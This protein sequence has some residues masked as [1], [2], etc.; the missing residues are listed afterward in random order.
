MHFRLAIILLVTLASSQALE[1]FPLR[2]PSSRTSGFTLL[3]AEETGVQ[4]VSPLEADHPLNYLYHSG[5]A[6]GSVML[7]DI[8]LD[9]WP[10]FFLTN[11]PAKNALYLQDPIQPL[12]FGDQATAL[13]VD[14]GNR[15]GTGSA[16]VDIDNDGDLDLYVCS[17][18]G[19][20]ELY[21][22]QLVPTGKLSFVESAAKFGLDLVNASMMPAFADIDLD[23]DLDLFMLNNRVE[24]PGGRPT[25]PP[26]RNVNGKPEVLPEFAPYYHLSQKGG[27]PGFSMDTYGQPD[28]LYRNDEGKFVDVTATSGIAGI[29]HGLSA[30]WWDYNMD[31]YPDLYVGNDFTDPDRLYRND[32]DGTFTEVLG[33]TMPYCS[34]S[35]M[36]SASADLNNDGL[37]DLFSADMAATSHFKQKVNMGDMTQHRVLMET[38]WPRQTMRN[39]LYVNTG[40]H[41]FKETAFMSGLAQSDWTW[42][43]KLA[44]FDSDGHSD[45][46]LT[47]GM[48]RNFSDSDIPMT[49]NMLVGRTEFEIYKDTPPMLEKNLAYRNRGGLLFEDV[50]SVWGL[51]SLGMSYGAAHGDLDRDGDLDL[52]VMNLNAPLGIYRNDHHAGNRMV[53]QLVGSKSNRA[54]WG[55]RVSMKAGGV[56]QTRFL[57][58]TTGFQGGDLAE[59]HFG[60]GKATQADSLIVHW[61]SGRC[62]ELLDLKEG[63]RYMVIEPSDRSKL[64]IPST[65]NPLFVEKSQDMG[66][67]YKHVET[68]FDDY[69]V[70][71]LLP[72]KLSQLG[73]GMAWGDFDGDGDDDVYMGGAAGN[74]GVLFRLDDGKFAR[75]QGPW[76]QESAA[77]D[78]GCVWLDADV[79]GDLDLFVASGG[80]EHALG[81]E[82]MTDRLYLNRGEEG[83]VRGVETIP[84]AGYSSSVVAAADID[85]DGDVDLFVGSRSVPGKYPQMPKSRWLRNDGGR[86]SKMEGPEA[87]GLVTGATWAD[88]NDDGW[89]DLVVVAEWGSPKIL[90]S[91][92]GKRFRD[93]SEA[94]GVASLKGWW[95]GVSSEDIDSDGDLDLVVTNVG[96]NTK[97]GAASSKK[98]S[99]LY[100]GDMDGTG[101]AQIIEAK[102]G[103]DGILPIRGRSC[104]SRAM[105]FLAEKFTSYRAFASANLAGIYTPS[106]LDQAERFDATEF[107]TGILRNESKNGA[108]QFR[109]EPLPF[110][111]QATPNYGVSLIDANGDGH[112]DIMMVGNLYTREPETGLWRGALG[113]TLLGDGK[114]GFSELDLHES[115]FV[116]PGDGKSLAQTDLNADGRPDLVAAQ[117]NDS[118]LAFLGNSSNAPFFAVRLQGKPGNPSA[119]G[120]RVTLLFEDGSEVRRDVAS[121]SGYLSQSGPECFFGLGARKPKQLKVRW[122]QGEETVHSVTGARLRVSQ[123]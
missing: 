87:L 24:R 53:V 80:V 14:G 65:P 70:Q 96:L 58:P 25:K 71:P 114:G 115:G 48:A 67:R 74:A 64:Q 82:A 86:F 29:G 108:L 15:W 3:S 91:E 78:M 94:A 4:F 57:H 110:E 89:Q 120:A 121:G 43:V 32:Q 75:V 8:N 90:I 68:P 44:D 105:P 104:S 36:G 72:G 47:N 84:A 39:M 99:L 10:D 23:G 77:E 40:I 9:G 41:R 98:P 18:R 27:G 54:G 112:L 31:N 17:Y 13:G 109:F 45:V 102:P 107:R 50:S 79:D 97:Y 122:P 2:K 21:L 49:P 52:V 46:Y 61:P 60:L 73:P 42:A 22:N 111:A 106:S 30:T 11:G 116:V 7:G 62:S 55:S 92:G 81:S 123:P 59:L 51:D 28:R 66:L 76:V 33:E 63:H 85:R 118:V 113:T 35:S 119:V 37:P 101:M 34:W 19:A 56:T 103:N 95:N 38:G 1:S 26:F 12:S 83:F 117:N 6:C 16:M 20:H 5:F 93:Q 69:A 88:V 100:Y